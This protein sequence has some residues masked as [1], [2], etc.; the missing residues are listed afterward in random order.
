MRFAPV[1]TKAGRVRAFRIPRAKRHASPAT[2]LSVFNRIEL[3]FQPPTNNRLAWMTRESACFSFRTTDLSPFSV[4]R[5]KIIGL[6]VIFSLTI[7][8]ISFRNRF[9]ER[10]A[11]PSTFF[12]VA[13]ESLNFGDAVLIYVAMSTFVLDCQ[14]MVELLGAFY[15]SVESCQRLSTF[16]LLINARLAGQVGVIGSGLLFSQSLKTCS[17]FWRN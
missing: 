16:R 10:T 1:R 3:T 11:S 6:P 14:L 15:G 12:R 9:R 17:C 7:L 8:Q 4:C 5:L 2:L 13:T